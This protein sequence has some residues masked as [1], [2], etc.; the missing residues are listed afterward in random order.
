MPLADIEVLNAATDVWYRSNP[1]WHGNDANA[2][3]RWK[4]WICVVSVILVFLV[5]E[6]LPMVFYSCVL[7]L[8]ML[9]CS[10]LVLTIG[11]FVEF[12]V[13]SLFYLFFLG[14]CRQQ[15]GLQPH[16]PPPPVSRHGKGGGGSSSGGKR[17]ND[18]N[19]NRGRG[20]YHP[21]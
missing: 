13:L 9:A 3:A 19:R 6:V 4:D 16:T 7:G 12:L 18:N 8:D 5:V 17:G 10:T 21:Y 20:R 11:H 2:F 1:C 15:P 14:A